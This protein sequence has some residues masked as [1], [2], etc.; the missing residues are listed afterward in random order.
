MLR[1][2]T[3]LIITILFLSCFTEHEPKKYYQEAQC[4]KCY[5]NRLCMSCF[6]TGYV[7]DKGKTEKCFSCNGNGKC[8][9]CGG[10]G[11]IKVY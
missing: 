7:T 5:G 10:T 11:K 1:K 9:V 3:I 6:G 4:P 8:V 2:A